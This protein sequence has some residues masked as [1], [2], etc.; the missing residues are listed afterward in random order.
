MHTIHK[1][2]NFILHLNMLDSEQIMYCYLNQPC[3]F[4]CCYYEF[5]F[6]K[7]YLV[8]FNNRKPI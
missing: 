1:G 8:K 2:N 4:C 7:E 3:L 5:E 6:R